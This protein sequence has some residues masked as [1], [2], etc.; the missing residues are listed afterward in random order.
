MI[1]SGIK[2]ALLT[3]TIILCWFALSGLAEFITRYPG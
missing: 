3:Y 2:G 1:L